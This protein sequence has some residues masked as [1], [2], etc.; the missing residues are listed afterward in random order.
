MSLNSSTSHPIWRI[1]GNIEAHIQQPNL[2]YR[3]GLPLASWK[4]HMRKELILTTFSSNLKL[5][6]AHNYL[7]LPMLCLNLVSLQNLVI[8]EAL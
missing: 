1:V 2:S 7:P 8:P 6:Q 4:L 3:N 5:R